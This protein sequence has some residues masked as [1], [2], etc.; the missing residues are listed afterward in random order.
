MRASR[1]LAATA[2]LFA[3]GCTKSDQA[4][5]DSVALAAQNQAALDSISA[6]EQA[7]A[8]PAAPVDT[9]VAQVAAATTTTTTTTKTTTT[10]TAT[11]KSPTTKTAPASEG[12]PAPS[13]ALPGGTKPGT[14]APVPAPVVT[15]KPEVKP[16]APVTAAPP[17]AAVANVESSSGKIPYEENC[18][19][20]H[21][22]IGVPPKT[23]KAKFPKIV[24]FD[25]G[26]FAKV[27]SDS[28]MKVLANG[29][30]E[31]MK[32]F[33]GKLT[34]EQM[35]AVAAYIRTFGKD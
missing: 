11:T 10:R 22:V 31:D 21:G 29:V 15:S 18:R 24:T 16:S 28:V 7:S 12:K 2:I 30:D 32:S 8:T 17:A 19:K 33:K 26:F 6:A 27:S 35:L 5:A 13:A 23:M 34:R 9:A 3:F 1:F 20:C 14:T 25:A 4:P